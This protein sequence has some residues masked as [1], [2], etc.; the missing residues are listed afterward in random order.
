MKQVKK[1]MVS[2]T[3]NGFTSVRNWKINNFSDSVS[4]GGNIF[5]N[6]YNLYLK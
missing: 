5:N 4:Y 3:S 1:L 2:V 6:S